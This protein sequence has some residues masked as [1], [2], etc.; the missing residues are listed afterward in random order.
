MSINILITSGRAPI[1][2][3]LARLFSAADYHI[4]VVD[5][6]PHH[7]CSYSRFVVKNFVVPPPRQD[8]HGYINGLIE[9]IQQENINFLIPTCE[10]IFYIAYGL[11]RLTPYCQVFAEPLEK[12]QPLHNKWE[13]ICRAKQLG[14]TIPQ[15]WLIESQADLQNILESTTIDKIVLKPVYS[16]FANHVHFLS[17]PISHIP[18]LE[19]N[20]NRTWVAQE[21]IRG[22]HYCSYSIAHQ[23][24]IKAHAVYP[25][26]F[27]AGKGSCIYFQAVDCP[28]IWHWVKTFV[29]AENFTGQISFDFILTDD[30]VLYPLE[31]NPRGISAIHLFKP[32]DCLEK[33]FFNT[34]QDIIQPQLNQR[35]M[36]T[37]A[38]IIYGL[39]SAI[40]SGRL[41]EWWKIFIRTKDVIFR[42]DD[43][44][45][46]FHLWVV[47]GQFLIMSWQTKQTLQE[48]TT[49]DI[50]WDGEEIEELGVV[51]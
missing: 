20:Q 46:F 50:E 24:Q 11:D 10:D 30:G 42:I 15:T 29:A 32:E 43:P 40:I 35:A 38:M 16:R 9:I 31:C 37:I 39:P 51:K 5:S 45:P 22:Q 19:I 18:E 21:F 17:K 36:I 34:N 26:I 27:T 12:L 3:E 23:G 48:V 47:L 6:L 1:T 44:I 25:T 7:L 8:Y 49:R 2:L 13:F 41:W 28:V 14:L 4:F 33:A